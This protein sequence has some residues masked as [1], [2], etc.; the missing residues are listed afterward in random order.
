MSAIGYE[1]VSGIIKNQ[2]GAALGFDINDID[3]TQSFMR[4]G[5]SSLKTITITSQISNELGIDLD[6][7]AMLEHKNIPSLCDYI[8][9][10]FYNGVLK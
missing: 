2:I 7:T 10:N 6:P 5:L 9:E 4:M 8:V 1:E 3:Q